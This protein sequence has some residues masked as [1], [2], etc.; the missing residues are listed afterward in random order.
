MMRVL[1]V[2]GL[3]A[4]RNNMGARKAGNI[5]EHGACGSR[6]GGPAGLEVIYCYR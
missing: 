4:R 6:R 3:R 5:D 1:Q 2:E